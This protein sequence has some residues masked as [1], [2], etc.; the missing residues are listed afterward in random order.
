MTRQLRSQKTPLAEGRCFCQR[1][2]VAKGV[3]ARRG[4]TEKVREGEQ[5]LCCADRYPR[6]HHN[7]TVNAARRAERDPERARETSGYASRE[8]RDARAVDVAYLRVAAARPVGLSARLCW[9]LALLPPPRGALGAA[10]PVLLC[11]FLTTDSLT[12]SQVF[13][14]RSKPR[15]RLCLRQRPP[16]SPRLRHG[17]NPSLPTATRRTGC[18]RSWTSSRISS[19]T[20]RRLLLDKAVGKAKASQHVLL[21]L[22]IKNKQEREHALTHTHDTPDT[23]IVVVVVLQTT[24]PGSRRARPSLAASV[25]HTP[26][27]VWLPARRMSV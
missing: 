1:C 19:T 17:P 4:S 21:A 20:P 15:P 13:T 10:L 12:R 18:T 14:P 23:P 6:A 24:S 27:P 25:L 3:R 8:A 9:P 26:G 7:N 11:T 22:N 16:P 2:F 5:R